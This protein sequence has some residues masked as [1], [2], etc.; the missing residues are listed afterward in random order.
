MSEKAA[1]NKNGKFDEKEE[2]GEN[3]GFGKFSASVWW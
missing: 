1:Y 2:F 3:D